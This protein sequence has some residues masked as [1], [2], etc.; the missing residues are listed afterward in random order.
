M[1]LVSTSRSS[2]WIADG[3]TPDSAQPVIVLI[4]GAAGT[5]LDW[6]AELRR[7]P[8]AGVIAVDL[9]GHG[10]SPL[11]GRTHI[12]D[13]AADIVALLDTLNIPQ[14]IMVG[15]SMGGAI[16]Q[17]LALD[18]PARVK[19]IALIAT[20]AK[21]PI[22]PDILNYAVSDQPRVAQLITAWSWVSGADA[23]SLQNSTA[24]I[25][26]IAPEVMHGD[27]VACAGFDARP[28]LNEIHVP[29]LVVGAAHDQMLPPKFSQFLHDNIPNSTLIM[30]EN[31]GHKLILEQ[32]KIVAEAVR[33]WVDQI[34]K[35]A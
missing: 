23:A 9:P 14:A 10:K 29:T 19:G 32:P 6:S 28:R 13:Y 22:H 31:A 11:P 30:V 3:R 21:I 4:H 12:A 26:Q 20:G 5:R 35:F 16:A 15:H 2:I 25:L 1:S 33:N 24:A 27:F 18:Y 34:A 7:L 17:A 8:N